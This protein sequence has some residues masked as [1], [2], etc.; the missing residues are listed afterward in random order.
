MLSVIELRGRSF[1]NK[2]TNGLIDGMN[3]GNQGDGNNGESVEL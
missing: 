2:K 1:M 3:Q